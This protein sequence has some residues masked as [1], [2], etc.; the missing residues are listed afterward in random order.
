[1]NIFV[2]D[3]D[4]EVAASL[5]CDKHVVKMILETAQLLS[6]ARAELGLS[7]P[8][9]PNHVNHPCSI[10]TRASQANY[11]WLRRLGLALYDEYQRRYDNRVHKS[12]ELIRSRA[13]ATPLAKAFP[14]L[15]RT[16][17]A[18][19]MPDEYRHPDAVVAYRTYYLA[20]KRPLLNDDLIARLT[21]LTEAT[22]P[23]KTTA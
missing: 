23:T 20:D 4:P 1:M 12:G 9:K 13:L 19:A 2:L 18:Q 6:T 8:Y 17:F 3:T 5:H 7:H 21:T 16:P 22:C 15:K 14:A 10:W 11:A